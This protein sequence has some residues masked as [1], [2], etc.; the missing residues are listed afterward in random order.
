MSGDILS[1]IIGVSIVLIGS[2]IAYIFQKYFFSR[3]HDKVK[4]TM[5]K[6]S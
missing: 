6:N 3:Y 1:I 2:L 4:N 5:E